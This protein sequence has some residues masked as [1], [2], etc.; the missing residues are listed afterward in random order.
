MCA[1]Q[2]VLRMVETF[3][4]A[5]MDPP[6]HVLSNLRWIRIEQNCWSHS[7]ATKIENGPP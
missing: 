3:R 4:P 2:P 7:S 5:V 1:P 6:N